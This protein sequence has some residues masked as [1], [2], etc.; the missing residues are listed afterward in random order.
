[1]E[2]L[3]QDAG[4]VDLDASDDVEI[5]LLDLAGTIVTVNEAWLRFAVENDGDPART[6][7]GSSFLGACAAAGA[8]PVASLAAAAV[9]AALAG[10]LPAP[11]TMVIPCHG[12]AVQRWF[13]LM[14]S[15]RLDEGGAL[16]GATVLLSPR[17][18][19]SSEADTSG[20]QTG[21]DATAAPDHPSRPVPAG[22]S[23]AAAELH[24]RVVPGLFAVGVDL[25]RLLAGVDDVRTQRRRLMAGIDTIDDAIREMRNALFD[26]HE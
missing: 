9:S 24:A 23:R 21:Y 20:Y 17:A 16:L 4:A 25:Q 11:L 18:A 3:P 22:R 14:I 1:M 13:D 26:P 2:T 15:P 10:Q 6:G 12:P 5:A 19:P 7:V 8:D